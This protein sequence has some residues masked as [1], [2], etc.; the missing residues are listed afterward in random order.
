MYREVYYTVVARPPHQR[1]VGL[2]TEDSYLGSVADLPGGFVG[3]QQCSQQEQ[4]TSHFTLTAYL[5][6]NCKINYEVSDHFLKI[7]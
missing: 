5:H 2:V 3:C 7:I 1:Q 4:R 6:K